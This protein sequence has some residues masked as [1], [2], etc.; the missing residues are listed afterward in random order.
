M[1]TKLIVRLTFI[2]AALVA[3]N[4]QTTDWYDDNILS[5]TEAE[6]AALVRAALDQ[7]FPPALDRRLG[8]LAV[9]RSSLALPLIEK[10]VEEVFAS[11]QTLNTCRDLKPPTFIDRAVG[12]IRLAGNGEALVQIAKLATINEAR[13][14]PF[15]ETLLFV[16]EDRGDVNPFAVAYSVFDPGNR[17]IERRIIAGVDAQLA[18]SG[19][20]A[21]ISQLKRWW[22]EAIVARYGGVPSE[23]QWL[24]DP[25]VSRLKLS[26]LEAWRDDIIRL[27]AEAVENGQRR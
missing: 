24:S 16:S 6:Q 12:V 8:T 3:G 11:P 5:T 19:V 10:K 1:G 17:F 15:A 26:R 13:F 7:C 4:A 9:K 23:A 20:G 21:R 25:I 22:A 18:G 2:A 14:G 27:A